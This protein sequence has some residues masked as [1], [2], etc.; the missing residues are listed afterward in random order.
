MKINNLY[1]NFV[2]GYPNLTSFVFTIVLFLTL[3]EIFLYDGFVANLIHIDIRLLISSLII[4]NWLTYRGSREQIFIA[5]LNKLILL[6]FSCILYVTAIII[7][8]KNGSGFVFSRIHLHPEIIFLMLAMSLGFYLSIKTQKPKTFDFSASSIF[9]IILYT[10]ISS[11]YYTLAYIP[12]YMHRVVGKDMSTKREKM[13]S[14]WGDFYDR[15]TF[16]ATS[17][18]AESSISHPPQENPWQMDGNQ[19]LMRYFLYPRKLYSAPDDSFYASIGDSEWITITNGSTDLY[20]SNLFPSW[21]ILPVPTS[22]VKTL[23]PRV[24]RATI[25]SI[26]INDSINQ[27][28]SYN[29]YPSEVLLGDNGTIEN[30]YRQIQVVNPTDINSIRVILNSNMSY[31]VSLVLRVKNASGSITDHE[32]NQNITKDIEVEI[33]L[34]VEQLLAKLNNTDRIEGFYIKYSNAAPLPYLY[35]E[36]IAKIGLIT[37]NDSSINSDSLSNIGT[38][39]YSKGEY[40]KAKGYYQQSILLRENNLEAILG[41]YYLSI[42]DYDKLSEKSYLDKL[43][44]LLIHE[45]YNLGEY[46]LLNKKGN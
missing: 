13:R 10:F 35:H 43:S 45:K 24:L 16:Y 11:S 38:Y 44:S 6:P 12:G 33:S 17:T 42:R 21:P 18:P 22:E 30:T 5:N 31:S 37:S 14:V 25:K 20:P 2:K 1:N 27:E 46:L 19:L 7:E 41:L 3:A 29:Y 9:I 40:E 26:F 8:G 32:S 36:G 28:T 34:D 4:C 23:V 15:A 39:N